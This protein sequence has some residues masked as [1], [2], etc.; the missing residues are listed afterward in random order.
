MVLKYKMFHASRHRPTADFDVYYMTIHVYEL[1]TEY[2]VLSLV[3]TEHRAFGLQKMDNTSRLSC[4][5][6]SDET[7]SFSP[8]PSHMMPTN[9]V[10]LG[11]SPNLRSCVG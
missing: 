9:D 11:V 4:D 6:S 1:D 2:F 7:I 3:A 8:S 10:M 5:Y